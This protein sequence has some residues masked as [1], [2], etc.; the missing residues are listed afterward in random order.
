MNRCECSMV[1]IDEDGA[2]VHQRACNLPA[3]ELVQ[4][5]ETEFV[6]VCAHHFRMGRD[7]TLPIEFYPHPPHFPDSFFHIYPTGSSRA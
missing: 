7:D 4:V 5:N 2:T 6:N 1:W 3:A